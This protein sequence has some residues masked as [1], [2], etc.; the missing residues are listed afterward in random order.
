ML[1]ALPKQ[2]L[3]GIL[4]LAVPAAPALCKGSQAPEADAPAACHAHAQPMMDAQSDS[5]VP[6]PEP[7]CCA[8]CFSFL[9]ANA[10]SVVP[11]LAT[12]LATL[13][14]VLTP[15]AVTA[16]ARAATHPPPDRLASPYLQDSPPLLN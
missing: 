3:A 4:A 2:L 13:P 10:P 8:A 14:P 7:G 15:P 6:E 16:C 9:G 1:R 5:A 11:P 12:G